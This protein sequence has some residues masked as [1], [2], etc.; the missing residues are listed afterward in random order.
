MI[1]TGQHEFSNRSVEF[2]V[3]GTALVFTIHR[4]LHV[5][6]L[7]PDVYFDATFKVVPALLY[8]LF[9]VFARYA[10]KTFLMTRKSWCKY[11]AVFAKV[12]TVFGYGVLR[13]R[14]RSDVP[15][16]FRQRDGV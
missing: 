15:R 13:E 5:L 6:S 9:T 10:W 1:E 11:S 12:Y 16:Q 4:Q 8:Q 7:A 14:I 2:C 3:T